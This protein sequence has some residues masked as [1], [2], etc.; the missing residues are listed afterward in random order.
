MKKLFLIVCFVFGLINSAHAGSCLRPPL[1]LQYKNASIV[2]R[3]VVTNE[4]NTGCGGKNAVFKVESIYKGAFSEE[5]SVYTGDSCSGTGSFFAKG[6]EYIVFATQDGSRFNTETGEPERAYATY[7]CSGTHEINHPYFENPLPFFEKMKNRA[8]AYDLLIEA[9]NFNEE[10][11]LKAKIEHY[12][13]WHDYSN[14]ELLLE[15]IYKISK[16][17]WVLLELLRSLYHQNKPEKIWELYLKEIKLEE[18]QMNVDPYEQFYRPYIH[19]SAFVL[20]NEFE[21]KLPFL[22][23]SYGPSYSQVLPML[24]SVNIKG[25]ARK[26][27]IIK[28]SYINHS[29]FQALDFSN[30]NFEG[31]MIS[32]TE[33]LS[34]NFE[35]TNFG[36]I[37]FVSSKIR[38]SNLLGADF[39]N[40]EFRSI[41][42]GH[43]KFDCQTKWPEGFD[44]IAAGAQNVDGECK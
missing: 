7:A 27:M 35:N 10:D 18:T 9:Q 23:L 37:I 2:F 4:P 20:N 43:S 40:V 22:M 1:V 28:F 26:S 30:S 5:I 25:L 15:K 21:K 38:N 36:K 29:N 6:K 12:L 17:K 24:E 34:S 8:E 41:E 3:G 14:A 32:E 42:L 33:F 19:F 16:D 39:S 44:P 11:V 13:Y 31:E